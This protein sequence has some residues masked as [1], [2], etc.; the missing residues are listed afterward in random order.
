MLSDDPSHA[1]GLP[2]CDAFQEVRP[3]VEFLAPLASAE[4]LRFTEEDLRA[5]RFGQEVQQY[6]LIVK[7]LHVGGCAVTKRSAAFV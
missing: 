4:A 5:N 2:P 1:E 7:N 3:L 6:Q